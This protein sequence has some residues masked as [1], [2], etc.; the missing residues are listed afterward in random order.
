[1][2]DISHTY[3]GAIRSS[4]ILLYCYTTM[5]ATVVGQS[6]YYISIYTLKGSDGIIEYSNYPFISIITSFALTKVQ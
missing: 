4:A 3:P 2:S 6:I 1:M 5:A